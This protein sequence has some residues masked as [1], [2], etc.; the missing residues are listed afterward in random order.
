MKKV[1]SDENV[2]QMKSE[3]VEHEKIRGASQRRGFF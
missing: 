1:Y 3:F 2:T